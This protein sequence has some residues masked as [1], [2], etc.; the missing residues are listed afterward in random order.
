MIIAATGHRPDKLQNGH[1][2]ETLARLVSL[3]KDYLR[4]AWTEGDP[5][6]S[7]MALGWDTAWALAALDL[8][9]DLIAAVPFKGQESK[10]PAK[11]QELY[12]DILS[13]AWLV[14]VVMEGGYSPPSFQRRNEFMVNRADRICAL[15]DG[16]PGGTGN[17]I[18]YA[19]KMGKADR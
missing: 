8:G 18:R 16:S 6:I 2:D 7:G 14:E 9:V 10:W 3:A 11:S 5:V 1:S 12:R 17:C 15:W 13:R 19:T 4:R